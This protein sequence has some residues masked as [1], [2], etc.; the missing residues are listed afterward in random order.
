M[1][2]LSRFVVCLSVVSLMAAGPV[3]AQNSNTDTGGSIPQSD[4]SGSIGSD[5][6]AYPSDAAPVQLNAATSQFV[7]SLQA[8]VLGTTNGGE[9]PVAVSKQVT[10]LIFTPSPTETEWATQQF[11]DELIEHGIPE[12]EAEALTAALTG[13]FHDNTIRAAQIR[14]ALEAFNAVVDV[15]PPSFLTQPPADFETVRTI[16]TTLLDATSS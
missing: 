2:L 7:Q 10:S 16:L 9:S 15:A 3:W 1:S 13:L 4:V 8:G 6:G 5:L 12:A 11:A 14:A